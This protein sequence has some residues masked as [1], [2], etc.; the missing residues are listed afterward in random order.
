MSTAS[1]TRP[2]QR[3]L[4]SSLWTAL[5]AAYL[6]GTLALAHSSGYQQGLLL[7]AG[8]FAILALSLDLVAGATGLYSLGHAGL[9]AIGAYGTVILNTKYGWNVFVALP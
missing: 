6:G 5:I 7:V 8:S 2:R 3:V 4:T 9:F 1:L